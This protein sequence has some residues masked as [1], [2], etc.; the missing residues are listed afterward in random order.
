MGCRRAREACQVAGARRRTAGPRHP[1][2][3]CRRGP[4]PD[5]I[6]PPM[7]HSIQRFTQL[8]NSI[9]RDME[10]MT[11]TGFVSCVF[12]LNRNERKLQEISERLD[13]AHR[14][15]MAASALRLEAQ[16]NET[17]MELQKMA[18]ATNT[19]LSKLLL[20]ARFQNICSFFGRPLACKAASSGVIHSLL[21]G[22]PAFGNSNSDTSHASFGLLAAESRKC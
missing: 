17:H 19:D 13:N 12:H 8:L 4:R 20:S 2:R 1:P 10:A 16:H 7:L 11:R 22:H 6:S 14:D 18:V 21:N 5:S 15:F 9:R 3:Y